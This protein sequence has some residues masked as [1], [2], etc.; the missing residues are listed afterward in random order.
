MKIMAAP[1]A[2]RLMALALAFA[3]REGPGEAL[4]G[5]FARTPEDFWLPVEIDFIASVPLA[6]SLLLLECEKL[7]KYMAEGNRQLGRYHDL[8]IQL[9]SPSKPSKPKKICCLCCG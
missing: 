4:S 8:L 2:H 5:E 3:T 1:E 6:V 7:K 9:I